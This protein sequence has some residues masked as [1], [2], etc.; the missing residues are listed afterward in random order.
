MMVPMRLA[1]RRPSRI[2]PAKGRFQD[3]S[4]RVRMPGSSPHG[5]AWW[6]QWIHFWHTFMNPSWLIMWKVV[7]NWFEQLWAIKFN[8]RIYSPP[9]STA[10]PRHHNR[11]HA[12]PCAQRMSHLNL[13]ALFPWM[14][15]EKPS[16]MFTLQP[17]RM[18]IG[19]RLTIMI[20]VPI[21]LHPCMHPWAQ[22]YER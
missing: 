6:I 1:F 10:L 12:S 17:F 7:T 21:A 16:S 5:T 11:K 20:S 14:L 15:F 9:H 8:Q 13:S 4:R 3:T 22:C 19:F 18:C 2:Q